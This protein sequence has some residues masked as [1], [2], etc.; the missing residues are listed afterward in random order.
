MSIIAPYH[1]IVKRS[2]VF[3][4]V[5]PI[6]IYYVLP[7][8]FW[9][10]SDFSLPSRQENIAYMFQNKDFNA[11]FSCCFTNFYN[12]D[13]LNPWRQQK[14]PMKSCSPKGKKLNRRFLLW[15]VCCVLFCF[16]GKSCETYPRRW[17]TCSFLRYY[18]I[19]LRDIIFTQ[20]SK[21]SSA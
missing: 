6:K 18:F 20:L 5:L 14:N 9:V 4:S 12:T 8:G 15:S 1:S 2:E 3:F 19:F 21:T 13:L 7:F 11:I 10:V 16:V 17:E